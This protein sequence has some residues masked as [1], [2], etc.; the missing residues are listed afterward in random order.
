VNGKRHRKAVLLRGVVAFV[1]ASTP[2]SAYMVESNWSTLLIEL[3]SEVTI[4][5]ACLGD[6]TVRV[7][8]SWG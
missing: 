1:D 3:F 2:R 8:K 7:L 5:V 4:G 6:I